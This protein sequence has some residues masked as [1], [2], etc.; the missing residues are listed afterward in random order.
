MDRIRQGDWQAW[1]AEEAQ[2]IAAALSLRAVAFRGGAADGDAFDA[3]AAQVLIGKGDQVVATFRLTRHAS[4]A[5]AQAG[6]AAQVYD[7]AALVAL[8]WP[9][10]ELGR[11]C[12]LPGLREPD[13]IRL[14]WAAVARLTGGWGTRFLFGC[15]SFPGT[16]PGAWSAP[17]GL[18]A[19]RALAPPD[20]APGRKAAEVFALRGLP[21]PAD[22]AAA[23]ARLPGLLRSYLALGGRVS[24]HAVVDRD[25]RTFHLFTGLDLS[26]VPPARAARLRDLSS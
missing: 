25:L 7:L 5:A 22:G 4:D 2:D 12:T 14:A 19:E 18:L 16:D 15:T 17:L 23:L 11:F 8:G 6:Y 20:W 13:A 10:A 3:G 26:L 9:L 21:A 1:V 24:D